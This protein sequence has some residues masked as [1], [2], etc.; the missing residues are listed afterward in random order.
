MRAATSRPGRPS[1]SSV[2]PPVR[3]AGQHPE[4][5]VQE[6]LLLLGHERPRQEGAHEAV[7]DRFP[8]GRPSH[9]VGDANRGVVDRAHLDV[10][11]PRVREPLPQGRGVLLR[12]P[13]EL[14][15][16]SFELRSL[17]APLEAHQ[18]HPP[19]VQGPGEL[20]RVREWQL[21]PAHEQALLARPEHEGP[22]GGRQLGEPAMGGLERGAAGRVIG[23]VGREVP[24]GDDQRA[25]GGMEAEALVLS[26]G[27]GPGAG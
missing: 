27:R 22:P 1:P 3:G 19:L 12:V 11:E 18:S 2:P 23:R 25:H 26:R 5:L 17:D 9:L 7:L 16:E 10:R 15:E 6:G 24:P 14:E 8:L 13:P 20:L 21:R 4:H